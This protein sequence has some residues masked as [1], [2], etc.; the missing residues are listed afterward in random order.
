MRERDGEKEPSISE[1]QKRKYFCR[2]DWTIDSL[3]NRLANFD[4]SRMR[5]LWTIPPSRTHSEQLICPDGRVGFICAR[6]NA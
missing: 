3:L 6:A 1:K 5:F 2:R 4:F